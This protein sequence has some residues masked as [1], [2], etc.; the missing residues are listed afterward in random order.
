MAAMNRHERRRQRKLQRQPPAPTP[1]EWKRAIL[2][3][4]D[5]IDESELP[6]GV[7]KEQARQEIETISHQARPDGEG[8]W[9]VVL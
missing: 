7:T 4:L 5:E 8:G 3:W 2:A 9:E 1:R 6:E